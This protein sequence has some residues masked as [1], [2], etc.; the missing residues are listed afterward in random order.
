MKEIMKCGYF[1]KELVGDVNYSDP[2]YYDIA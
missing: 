2:V 1:D